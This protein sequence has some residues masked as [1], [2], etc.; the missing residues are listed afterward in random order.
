VANESAT[1]KAK[2]LLEGVQSEW[3]MTPNVV[4]TLANAPAALEGYLN[5][6]KALAG[7]VLPAELREQIA[8]AVAQA[9][10]CDYCLA[11]HCAI[12]K[13]VGLSD[14][15]IRDARRGLSPDT[16]VDTVLHFVWQMVERRGW[17]D[18]DAVARLRAAGFGDEQIVEIIASVAMNMF[19][20]YLNHVA[21]T[22]VDFPEV[23]QLVG[24]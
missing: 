20:N 15:A 23:L 24:G 11:A 17:V 6:S 10:R 3:G 13:S 5:L 2:Q 9:N 4:R 12:G 18:D 19:T 21:G 1:G 22:D 8:V 16:K 14:D 7:G